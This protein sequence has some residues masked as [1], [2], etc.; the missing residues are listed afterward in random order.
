MRDVRRLLSGKS[1]DVR[2]LNCFR[3]SL[4][5]SDCGVSVA[6]L[7]IEN[8]ELTKEP[9]AEPVL[10]RWYKSLRRRLINAGLPSLCRESLF[11]DRRILFPLNIGGAHWILAWFEVELHP[12]YIADPPVERYSQTENTVV[13]L[14]QEALSP[15]AKDER[16]SSLP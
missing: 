16:M 10:Q 1:A 9:S 6:Q 15:A 12:L 4:N 13:R 14:L 3:G 7:G 2:H 8:V 11:D 5:I